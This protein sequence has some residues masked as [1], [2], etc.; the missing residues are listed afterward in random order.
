[1][2]DGLF[3]IRRASVEEEDE[4]RQD[5]GLLRT[6]LVSCIRNFFELEDYIDMIGCLCLDFGSG[7]KLKVKLQKVIKSNAEFQVQQPETKCHFSN[8]LEEAEACSPLQPSPSERAELVS[9]TPASGSIPYDEAPISALQDEMIESCGD[10][11]SSVD[12]CGDG[13]SQVTSVTERKSFNLS[14]CSVESGL[15]V[16]IDVVGTDSSQEIVSEEHHQ[17]LCNGERSPNLP[18]HMKV[19]VSVAEDPLTDKPPEKD[20]SG[21]SG[22]SSNDSLQGKHTCKFSQMEVG[23]N[24]M[25]V[26]YYET[27]QPT[28]SSQ[29]ESQGDEQTLMSR[30]ESTYLKPVDVDVQHSSHGSVFSQPVDRPLDMSTF[31]PDGDGNTL[32][33]LVICLTISPNEL[34]VRSFDL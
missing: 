9:S 34:V 25:E 4:N 29:S 33:K 32:Q 7:R 31:K 30:T 27:A 19:S 23:E 8:M 20:M 2:L 13:E 26:T 3:Y 18:K 28:Y 21:A 15:S 14:S 1:M 16:E 24:Q 22:V 17:R 6:S 12:A 10:E 11:K 5:L